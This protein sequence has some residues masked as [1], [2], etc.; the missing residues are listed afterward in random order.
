MFLMTN[1]ENIKHKLLAT[2]NL[3]FC[4]AKTLAHPYYNGMNSS[5]FHCKESNRKEEW[6]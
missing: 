3:P 5:E 2:Q 4:D 6:M 1:I